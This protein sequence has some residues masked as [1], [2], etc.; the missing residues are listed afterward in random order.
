MNGRAARFKQWKWVDS[1]KG[2]GLF[3]L[4][5]DLGEK[6]DL[7][8]SESARRKEMEERWTAWKQK[9]NASEPR[10]PFRDY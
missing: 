2:G 7:S 6:H 8:S 10:G 1:N 5:N 3:D 9:M 4:S